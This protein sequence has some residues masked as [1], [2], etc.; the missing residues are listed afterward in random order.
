MFELNQQR[1]K[2]FVDRFWKAVRK[3]SECEDV[4][5]LLSGFAMAGFL[6]GFGEF[7]L[8]TG[9]LLG[10]VLAVILYLLLVEAGCCAW[11]VFLSVLLFFLLTV[12]FLLIVF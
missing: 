8:F 12:G 11:N 7:G 6:S 3:T 10:F 1:V 9:W 4:A 5:W 2:F